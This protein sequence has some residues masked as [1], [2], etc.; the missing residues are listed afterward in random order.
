MSHTF[1]LL[2]GNSSPGAIILAIPREGITAE[3]ECFDLSILQSSKFGPKLESCVLAANVYI[4]LVLV[5]GK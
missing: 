3:T 1:L 4:V 5:P 2:C